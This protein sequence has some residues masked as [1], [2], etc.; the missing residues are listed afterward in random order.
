M[1]SLT[2]MVQNSRGLHARPAAQL[3][4]ILEQ[5]ACACALSMDGKT[6][7][8]RDILALMAFGVR[9]GSRITFTF[10]GDD[11]ADATAAVYTFLQ[12]AL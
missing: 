11:E 10:A 2:H 9:C 5:F 8:P 6:I 4:Q 12:A 7:D 3:I 1:K